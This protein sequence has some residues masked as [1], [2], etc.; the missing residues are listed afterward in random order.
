MLKVRFDKRLVVESR[1]YAKTIA[2]DIYNRFIKGFS[3]DSIERTTLRF[4]GIEGSTS[5][6]HPKVNAVVDA[7]KRQYDITGGVLN[8]IAHEMAVSQVDFLSAVDIIINGTLSTLKPSKEAL[9]RAKG[10]IE[11]I[12]RKKYDE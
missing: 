1:E 12:A 9:D 11:E 10:E 2:T 6:G 7:I 4:L 5:Y 3:T 8:Y